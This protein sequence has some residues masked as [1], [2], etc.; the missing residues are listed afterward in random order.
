[1]NETFLP[2]CNGSTTVPKTGSLGSNPRVGTDLIVN[3]SITTCSIA[4]VIDGKISI[5][6]ADNL[7]D[8]RWWI[9]RVNVQSEKNKGTGTKLLK[10]LIEEILKQ[11]NF[12]IIVAPGGYSDKK[13]QQIN[14]YKKNGFVETEEK[15]LLIF[16]NNLEIS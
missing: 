15:S 10:R 11:G 1:M 3:S 4:Q 12:D 16:K 9:G 14:F 7:F 5:A 13:E 2:G 6:Q 8:G